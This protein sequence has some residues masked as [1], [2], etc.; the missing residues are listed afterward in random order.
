MSGKP[1][2]L[3]FEDDGSGSYNGKPFTYM[4]NTPRQ[5]RVGLRFETGES[6]AFIVTDLTKETLTF[7]FNNSMKKHILKK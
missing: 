7:V 3:T 6:M 2:E 4:V 1:V 5:G